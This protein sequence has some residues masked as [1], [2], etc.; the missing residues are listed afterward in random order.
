MKLK[1]NIKSKMLL[2][3]LIVSSLIYITAL[4]YV[5]LKLNEIALNDAHKLADSYA[6]EYANYTKANLNVDIDMARATAQAF[7]GYMNIKENDRNKI[8]KEI[9]EN[10]IKENPNFLS[11]WITW[12]LGAVYPEWNKPFGRE[13]I[14]YYRLGGQIK[15]KKE[16]IDTIAGF[17]KGAYYDIMESKEEM[18]MDP[19]FFTYKEGEEEMLETSVA[20]PILNKNKFVGLAGFDIGMAR[21][22]NLIN[23]IHPLKDSYG[24]IISNNATMV[25]HPNADFTGKSLQS[26]DFDTDLIEKIKSG[27][28]FSYINTDKN[29]RDFYVSN[30]PIYI[31]KSS[32]PWSFAFAVPVDVIMAKAKATLKR[33]IIVGFIGLIILSLVVLFIATTIS[34][35]IVKTTK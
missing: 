34:K 17:N 1:M 13:R 14:T 6:G 25:A 11:T 35:P 8:Y 26:L 2:Y 5:S 7:Q 10:L 18:V 24:Y 12:E 20:V 9:L 30:V 16:I 4:G 22:Q 27:E 23:T 15:Y 32:T 28:K 33:T 19:Y 3:I 31:G 29:N 21:F